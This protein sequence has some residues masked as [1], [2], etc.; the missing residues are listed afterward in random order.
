MAPVHGVKTITTNVGWS[1]LS[2]TATFG[3]KFV[4]VPILA[5]LLSPDEFGVVAIALTVVQFLTMIGGAGLTAA[6]IMQQDTDE[7][8]VH[9]VFWANLAI[10]CLMS[11]FLYAGAEPLGTLMGAPESGPLLQVMALLIPLQ[12]S[13]DVAYTLLAKRM[14]FSKDAMWSTISE[15]VA[16]IAAVVMAY[17]GFGVWALVTQLFCAAL[18][19]LVGLY[20]ASRYLPR[21]VLRPRKLT[22]LLGFS[23]GVMGSEI[24]NFVTF[25]SPMIVIARLLGLAD[26]GAYSVANRF[27]SIPNQVV[28]TA[29][30]GV[31]FPAFSLMGDDRKRRSNALML[32]TQV[33]TVLLAPAMFGLWAVA[34]PAMTAIFGQGWAHAWP[35]LGLLALSKGIITPCSTFIP[36]LK[37][38]GHG[39]VLFWSAVIRAIVTTAAIAFAAWYGNLVDAMIALCVVNAVTLIGYS[40]VVFRVED[41]PLLSGLVT[42]SRSMINAMVMAVCVRAAMGHFQ[43]RLDNPYLELVAGAALGGLVYG[44]LLLL[45]ERT[46]L[47]K[48]LQLVKTR[49]A[50]AV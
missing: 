35:V 29:V 25:Q 9:S 48:L 36:Y 33:T 7:D 3:L 43:A 10:A 49:S 14:N 5:R 19:R 46:L 34:Q 50:V 1:V 30:M 24:A 2:K 21:P 4:T 8:T 20:S 11:F 26:A 44:V 39:R 37:G 38:T 12:L 32:S 16:A 15:S 6:L 13:G 18:I 47:R 27:A 17:H 45:T 28:L 23:S 41:I 31:L 40:W 22:P 42:S